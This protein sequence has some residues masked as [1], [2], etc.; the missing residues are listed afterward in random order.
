MLSAVV[1]RLPL[2]MRM[3]STCFETEAMRVLPTFQT[4]QKKEECRDHHPNARTVV[5]EAI[6]DMNI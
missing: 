4:V 6:F 5:K 2:G 3:R 1:G